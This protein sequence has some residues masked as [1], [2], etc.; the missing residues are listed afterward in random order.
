MLVPPARHRVPALQE[1]RRA[2]SC[3]RHRRA[4]KPPASTAPRTW[5]GDHG[6]PAELKPEQARA[7][8][9]S[10]GEC[11]EEIGN[12][13]KSAVKLK[14]TAYVFSRFTSSFRCSRGRSR[15]TARAR[16]RKRS[17]K[18]RVHATGQGRAAAR[19]RRRTEGTSSGFP[20]AGRA[21]A[22]SAGCPARVQQPNFERRYQSRHAADL[23]AST[24]ARRGHLTSRSALVPTT[25]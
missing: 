24:S 11:R 13:V 3:R 18:G 5:S 22:L 15:N 1:R 12:C 25:A 16:V 4:P 19:P 20:G 14:N 21:Y 17:R 6:R 10:A 2:S 23:T 9:A 7:R 8:A